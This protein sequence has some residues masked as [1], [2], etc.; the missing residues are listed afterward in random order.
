MSKES[1]QS[2]SFVIL[3]D[4]DPERTEYLI[5]QDLQTKLWM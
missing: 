4:V 3:S 2:R 5:I 1:L